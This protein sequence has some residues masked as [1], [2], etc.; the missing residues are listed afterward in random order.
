MNNLYN[1]IFEVL[2]DNSKLAK[3]YLK[4]KY[5]DPLRCSS[6]SIKSSKHRKEFMRG[7]FGETEEQAMDAIQD[8]LFNLLGVNSEYVEL[9]YGRFKDASGD[10][11]SCKV[12]AKEPVVNKLYNLFIPKGEYIYIYRK[13]R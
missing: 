5:A 6:K 13:Y 8:L 7:F 4:T 9:S 12:Y 10:Y 3:L 2:Q 11:D 1:Y